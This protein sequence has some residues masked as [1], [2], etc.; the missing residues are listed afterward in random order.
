M[1]RLKPNCKCLNCTGC[2]KLEDENFEGTY[3]CIGFRQGLPY[4]DKHGMLREKG[5]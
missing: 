3:I 4:F 1:K 5:R 2:N